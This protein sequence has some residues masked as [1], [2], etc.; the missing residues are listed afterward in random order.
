MD[1]T[2]RSK[3]IKWVPGS[4]NIY[5]LEF[6]QCN[7]EN[8]RER[9]RKREKWEGTGEKDWMKRRKKMEKRKKKGKGYKGARGRK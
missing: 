9:A 3:P 8:Y 4:L 1:S 7:V 2:S 5:I 6:K